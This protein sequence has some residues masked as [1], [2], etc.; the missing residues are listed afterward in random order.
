[1]IEARITELASAFFPS[2]VA[3]YI[4]REKIKGGWILELAA[5]I[6]VSMGCSRG[7]LKKMHADSQNTAMQGDDYPWKKEGVR[8]ERTVADFSTDDISAMH[9]SGYFCSFLS[10]PPLYFTVGHDRGRKY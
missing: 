4:G 1:M 3:L 8:V 5:R 7:L 2:P 10:Q 9:E 6:T